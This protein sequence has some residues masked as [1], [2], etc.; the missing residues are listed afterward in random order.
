MA[1]D[2]S[3][4]LIHILIALLKYYMYLLTVVFVSKPISNQVD[5]ELMKAPIKT[6]NYNFMKMSCKNIKK[7]S[8]Y[9]TQYH[10]EQ[11]WLS[12][13]EGIHWIPIEIRVRLYKFFY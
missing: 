11:I 3:N 12:R 2:I 4:T 10:I 9:D 8:Y 13:Q 1:H 5:T 6:S 7:S